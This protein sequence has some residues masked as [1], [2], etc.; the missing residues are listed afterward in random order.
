MARQL[1]HLLVVGSCSD[2]PA[3]LEVGTTGGPQA[4]FEDEIVPVEGVVSG[5][6]IRVWLKDDCLSLIEHTGAAPL[7]MPPL[8]STTV[9]PL[10]DYVGKRYPTSCAAR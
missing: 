1:D 2:C 7:G 4:T 10:G 9:R 5:G 3:T 8:D 6:A